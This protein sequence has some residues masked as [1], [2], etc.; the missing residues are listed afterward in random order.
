M[1]RMYYAE[2][3]VPVDHYLKACLFT[4]EGLYATSD[5]ILDLI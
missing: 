4:H 3:D 1:N 5:E 2:N